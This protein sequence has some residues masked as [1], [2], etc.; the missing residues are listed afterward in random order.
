MDRDNHQGQA[1]QMALEK[2]NLQ[3]VRILD[4]IWDIQQI[5]VKAYI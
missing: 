2:I 1:K 3:L 5:K 4:L